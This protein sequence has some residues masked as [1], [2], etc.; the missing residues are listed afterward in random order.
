LLAG[1]DLGG[2]LHCRRRLPPQSW[3]APRGIAHRTDK[4]GSEWT[5][6]PP[7][8]A[9]TFRQAVKSIPL[10]WYRLPT[11]AISVSGPN[12]GGEVAGIHRAGASAQLSRKWREQNMCSAAGAVSL[13]L[14]L[15]RRFRQITS[16]KWLP[17]N[18]LSIPRATLEGLSVYA[19]LLGVSRLYADRPPAVQDL[20][21]RFLLQSLRP[22]RLYADLPVS[23]GTDLP[24]VNPGLPGHWRSSAAIPREP[25]LRARIMGFRRARHQ[26]KI[27][28][29]IGEIVVGWPT[30]TQGGTLV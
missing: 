28:T 8:A 21:G 29:G 30:L 14:D 5:N 3:V 24:A 26:C 16:H 15:G 10:P 1:V 11:V 19:P 23:I 7:Y 22:A 13:A 9:H 4:D 2:T 17:G 12:G 20:A 18:R 6:I 27:A 25:A